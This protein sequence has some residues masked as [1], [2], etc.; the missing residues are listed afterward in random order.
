MKYVEQSACL[1]LK[2][3]Q[4]LAYINYEYGLG[5]KANVSV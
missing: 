5:I 2:G 4:F 3:K 1:H